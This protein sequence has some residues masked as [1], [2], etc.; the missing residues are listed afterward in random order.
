MRRW[1]FLALLLLLLQA[2]EN[3][4]RSRSVD[5]PVSLSGIANC[6]IKP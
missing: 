3:R 2:A 5:P 1:L 6:T 4:C